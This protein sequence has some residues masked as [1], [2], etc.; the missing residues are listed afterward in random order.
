VELAS[1]SRRTLVQRFEATAN[2]Q[3]SQR[4]ALAPLEPGVLVS[5]GVQLGDNV[6]PGQVL[7]TLDDTEFRE[8][9]SQAEA[10]LAAAR[11]TLVGRVAE[12]DLAAGQ[13]AR[14]KTLFAQELTAAQELEVA[15]T[16]LGSA[17]ALVELAEAEVKRTG[18]QAAEARAR[19]GRTRL[20]A[21]WAG[22]VAVRHLDPGTPVNAGTPVVTLVSREAL[23]AVLQV[24]E[25]AVA[26]MRPGAPAQVRLDALPGEA[27]EAQVSRVAPGVDLGTRLGQVELRLTKEVEPL[28]DGMLARVA[29]EFMRREGVLSVPQGAVVTSPQGP[30]VYVAQADEA[31]F[32][33]LKTGAADDGWLEVLSA[34]PAL[35]PG[36][37]VVTTGAHLLKSGSRIAPQ[38]KAVGT[39]KGAHGSP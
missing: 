10:A 8:R 30:G 33:A 18:A 28:R 36:T 38:N 1:V 31:R 17:Q 4:V 20:S 22:T 23:R 25:S 11:A 9:L 5:V 27:L 39:E 6:R 19:L 15:Q 7:A 21:P 29:V 2:L 24:P 12:R 3:A 32:I 14:E 37:L 26:H 16:R 35:L 34:S 13:L